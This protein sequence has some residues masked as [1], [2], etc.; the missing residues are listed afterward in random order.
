MLPSKILINQYFVS[1]RDSIELLKKNLSDLEQKLND[2]IEENNS[3]EGL[4]FDV[5][6]GEGDK[7]KITAKL[8][9]ARLKEI[10]NEPNFTE[11]LKAL[12]DYKNLL[13]KQTEIKN[14]LKI[15]L[16]GLNIKVENQ[17]AKLNEEEIKSLVVKNKW[18]AYLSAAVQSELDRVSQVLTSRINELAHRY[19]T[20]LPKLTKEIE[21]L[22]TKVKEHFKKMGVT[23]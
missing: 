13:E 23:W 5:I 2:V 20:P 8:L 9:N 10:S 17:Y 6:E 11:E 15:S 4:L 21:E 12:Q 16:D 7:K 18:L 3:E 19:S 1:E 14:K 22:S